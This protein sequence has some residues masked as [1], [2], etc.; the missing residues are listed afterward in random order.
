MH[1]SKRNSVCIK[2]F[3]ALCIVMH[4]FYINGC[5]Q[6]GKILSVALGN[7]GS[8]NV[9]LFLTLAGYGAY[10]SYITSAGEG[11]SKYI[12]KRF[13]KI[14]LPY[15]LVTAIW[16]VYLF[17]NT[18]T[19]GMT[20]SI[21]LNFLGINLRND[22]TSD[23][24]MWYMTFMFFWYLIFA[25]IIFLK[26]GNKVKISLLFAIAC[27]LHV[28]WSAWIPE[29]SMLM[30]ISAFGFPWGVLLAYISLNCTRYMKVANNRLFQLGVGTGCMLLF[31]YMYVSCDF[32]ADTYAIS[33]LF[34][35]LGVIFLFGV[36]ESIYSIKTLYFIGAESYMIYLTH[37]KI[38]H[39]ARAHLAGGWTRLAVVIVFVII[40]FVSWGVNCLINRLN[41]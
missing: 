29:L 16:S 33:S 36:I 2:G 14:Y 26:I 34:Y 27:F 5:L 13:S 23:F 25:M 41:K 40:I 21:L 38:I 22:G 19:D 30:R 11:R 12:Q 17:R 7:L 37:M 9:V 32:N 10:M 1:I 31:I 8:C 28:Y 3:A 35:S 6:G 39:L 20:M 15:L 24:V 18:C 4:H